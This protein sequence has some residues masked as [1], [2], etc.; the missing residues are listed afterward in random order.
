MYFV[1]V[2]TVNIVHLILVFIFII[3]IIA[4]GIVSYSYKIN[5]LV[6]QSLYLLGF[7]INLLKVYNFSYFRTDLLKFIIAY[8]EN[9]DSNDLELMIYGLVYCFYFQYR[10]SNIE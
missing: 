8:N 6:F 3:Q 10:A 7:M 5:I 4:P 1:S 9:K 2:Y